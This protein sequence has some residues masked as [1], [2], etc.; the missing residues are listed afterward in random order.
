MATL[1]LREQRH[2]ETLVGDQLGV[3]MQ[4]IGTASSNRTGD[5]HVHGA[6]C[7]PQSHCPTS[8]GM[9]QW[10]TAARSGIPCQLFEAVQRAVTGLCYTQHLLSWFELGLDGLHAHQANPQHGG[11]VCKAWPM[12][13]EVE[14]YGVLMGS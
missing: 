4:N 13:P 11:H 2:L 5:A 9:D 10:R 12:A 14:V 8:G 6:A 7:L 3:Q 1:N